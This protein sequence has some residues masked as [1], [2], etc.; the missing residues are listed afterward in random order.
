MLGR[1]A[2]YLE[3]GTSCVSVVDPGDEL[4]H[5]FR[6]ES[7]HPDLLGPDDEWSAPEILG[8]FRVPVRRFF[9]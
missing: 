7:C 1:I 3:M 9:E 8:E 4:I 6:P 5:L 2:E